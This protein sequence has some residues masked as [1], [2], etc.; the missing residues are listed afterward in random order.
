MSLVQK[1]NKQYR[2]GQRKTEE[3]GFMYRTVVKGIYIMGKS[4]YVD[5]YQG[6]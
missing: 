1:K 3:I 5:P 4:E 6:M 2:K